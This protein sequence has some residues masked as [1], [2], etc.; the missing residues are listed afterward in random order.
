ML[1][2]FCAR[3][4]VCALWSPAGGGG[5]GGGWPLGSRLWCL[6]WVCRFPI[7]ILGQVWYLI[8]SI[9]DL[10]NLITF[11]MVSGFGVFAFSFFMLVFQECDISCIK[12]KYF[13]KSPSGRLYSSRN[14]LY[15]YNTF[16][17]A[18]SYMSLKKLCYQFVNIIVFA[19]AFILLLFHTISCL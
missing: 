18:L 10:C 5:G 14:L 7:G 8:V 13:K 1:A 11:N 2:V 4:F 19:P 17:V 12:V 9:P 16:F 6:L 15:G 3:L